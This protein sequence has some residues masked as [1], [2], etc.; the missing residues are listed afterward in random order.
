[1]SNIYNEHFEKSYENIFGRKIPNFI[2]LDFM[3]LTY[4][5]FVSDIKSEFY[6]IPRKVSIDS[7]NFSNYIKS[8]P[9]QVLQ[10]KELKNQII[11]YFHNFY[12]HE[13]YLPN[14]F[15]CERSEIENNVTIAVTC[16]SNNIFKFLI[17]C[18][19]KC[20]YTF[21]IN[22]IICFDFCTNNKNIYT[23][24]SDK[25]KFWNDIDNRSFFSI[26]PEFINMIELS[27][28]DN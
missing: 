9:I 11:N 20:N 25:L 22:N 17:I 13:K 28:P 5:K 1:M 8:V 15:C 19:N 2:P 7:D 18:Q 23:I 12:N 24:T 6:I 4:S 3:D 26:T 27:Y 10:K 14:C 21:E 16:V